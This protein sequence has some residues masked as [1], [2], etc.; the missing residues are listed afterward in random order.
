PF[1]NTPL[2]FNKWRWNS[3]PAAENMS[4]L[5]HFSIGKEGRYKAEIRGDFF[6]VFNRHY[7]NAPDMGIND[8]TFGDVTG[9]AWAPGLQYSNRVGQVG[10]RFEF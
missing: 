1:G 9:V 7:F 6:D 2:Y 3:A 5:K 8:S 4:L 10:A